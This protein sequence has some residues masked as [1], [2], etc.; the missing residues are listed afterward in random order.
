MLEFLDVLIGIGHEGN[1]YMIPRIL[2]TGLFEPENSASQEDVLLLLRE[3][4]AALVKILN[5]REYRAP[6]RLDDAVQLL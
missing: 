1:T 6:G 2:V 5:T 3:D 4:I